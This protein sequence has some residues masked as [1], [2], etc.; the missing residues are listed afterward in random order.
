M[1][2]S[3]LNDISYGLYVVGTSANN[4]LAGCIVNTV[5]Q[6]SAE[7]EKV[8]VCLNHE[9]YTAACIQNTRE[10][11]VSILTENAPAEVIGQ[12]GFKSSREESKFGGCGFELLMNNMPVLT[13]YSSGW[14]HCRVEN[15]IDV[16][17]HVIFVAEVIDS[18]RISDNEPM[19]YSYYHNV[20]KGTSPKAAPT[21]HSESE[22]VGAYVCDVCGYVYRDGNFEDLPDDWVC[23]ICGVGKDRF[24]KIQK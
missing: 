12:F 17:T 20:V 9:S 23:P 19:T 11:T 13:E 5:I 18:K 15:I 6:V 10:F 8:T 22:D 2:N 3:I 4:T 21:Y 1:T 16:G 24:S 7:P 14:L